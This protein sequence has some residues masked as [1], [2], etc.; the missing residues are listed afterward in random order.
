MVKLVRQ[1]KKAA[2]ILACAARA[3]KLLICNVTRSV[4]VLV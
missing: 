1:A 2:P 4:F 3:V